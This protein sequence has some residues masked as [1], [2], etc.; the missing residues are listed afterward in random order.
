VNV[1]VMSTDAAAVA[2]EVAERRSAGEDGDRVCGFVGDDDAAA[3]AMGEDLFGK[4]DHV[5]RT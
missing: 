1:V 5:W 3:R 4:V 2:R